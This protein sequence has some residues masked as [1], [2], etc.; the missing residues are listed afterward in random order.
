MER[1]HF[2]QGLGGLGG[3]MAGC[4]AAA[5]APAPVRHALSNAHFRIELDP[6]NGSVRAITH[7]ADPAA[8]SWVGNTAN[9]PWQPRSLQWGLGYADIDKGLLHRGRWEEPLDITSTGNTLRVTYQVGALKVEVA[10]TLQGEVFTERYVFTNTGSGPLPL[11]SEHGAGTGMAIAAPFNDHYTDTRDVLE[12]RCHTHL[13]MGG[14]S[15][16]VAALR[17][18]GR[19]PHL[20]LVL[21]EG[22]LASYSI[23]GRDE[24]TSSNTRGTFLLHPSLGP[25]QPGQS[26]ALAWTLFWHGGWDD[27]FA[28]CAQHSP[29]FVRLQADRYTAYVGETIT[30]TAGVTAT[31]ASLAAGLPRL[32]TGQIPP[33]PLRRTSTGLT[34]ELKADKPGEM[35]VALVSTGGATSRLVVNVVPPL[36]ALIEARVRFIATR[37]Q[38]RDAAD[39][40]D[41]A[42]LTYDN[43]TN[44]IARY[45]PKR[46]HNEA[47]ERTGMGVL[48]ARWLRGRAQ[49]PPEVMDALTRYYRFHNAKLQRPDGYVFDAS[50][51]E[52]PRLYNWPWS[53]QL[54]LEMGRLTGD[55]ASYDAFVRTIESYYAN[56]GDAFYA[57][58]L[59]IF[60]GLAALRATGRT[61]AHARLLRLFRQHGEK[62]A[63]TGPNYPASEVNFEQSI[64]APAAQILLELHS[65]TGEARW[66]EAARPHLALLELF[67]GRQPD[68]HLHDIA[69]RHWDGYWFGKLRLWGDTFPHYWSSLTAL[70][71]AHYARSGAAGY[72]QRAEHIVRNNLS[73]FTPDGRGSAAFIYPKSVNGQLAHVADPLA[74]DQDWAL[75]H[76][77][78]LREI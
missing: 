67:N 77:L 42:F 43:Q 11:A 18:G 41:G 19:G 44:T 33:Q 75:V 74:N 24:V 57:I 48:L 31:D 49:R 73:L 30:L 21:T 20:G 37:Q 1:R 47:R 39:P 72:A 65:A 59:P 55:A 50:A 58:G 78:Q 70:A 14:N 36:D 38:V 15:A 5:A 61:D 68:H 17:M 40:L 13:W 29:G 25:L 62:I 12:H 4:H 34:A 52:R 28:R 8:M 9:A 26:R 23:T 60:D 71:F 7:P 53:A 64:V 54:H 22:S 3:L 35:R 32:V 46:D 66:L 6:A 56:G 27:F 76:A 10:R 16:W 63:T 69:I 2:V 51:L 45:N